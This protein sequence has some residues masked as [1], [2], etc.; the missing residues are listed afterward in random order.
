MQIYLRIF[1]FVEF[2][3]VRKNVFESRQLIIK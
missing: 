1:D 2:R 3:I